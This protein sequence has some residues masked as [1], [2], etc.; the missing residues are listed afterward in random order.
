M[1]RAPARH[2]VLLWRGSTQGT[3]GTCRINDLNAEGLSKTGKG[4]DTL[5]AYGFTVFLTEPLLQS[6]LGDGQN[7]QT[8]QQASAST[9]VQE[10][11][12]PTTKY[13]QKTGVCYSQSINAILHP[14][15]PTSVYN[16]PTDQVYTPVGKCLCHFKDNWLLVYQDHWILS[17]VMGYTSEFT[18]KPCL[19]CRAQ[20]H[21]DQHE[22]E[23]VSKE[24]QCL[25][26]KKAIV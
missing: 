12:Q 14:R 26:E 19:H 15:D 17:V 16:E 4:K 18:S 13:T 11:P 9:E 1:L 8:T 21:M 3:Q 22:K 5:G 24:M 20:T 2:K 7:L 10:K 25:L 6:P 23:L